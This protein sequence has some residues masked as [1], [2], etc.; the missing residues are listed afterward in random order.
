MVHR[1]TVFFV[2]T[3]AVSSGGVFFR[4]RPSLP[5]RSPHDTLLP[6]IHPIPV[7]FRFLQNTPFVSLSATPLPWEVGLTGEFIIPA[8]PS[9]ERR[10][11]PQTAAATASLGP[12]RR[13]S[14]AGADRSGGGA[15]NSSATPSRVPLQMRLEHVTALSLARN[16]LTDLDLSLGARA[17]ARPA[18]ASAPPPRWV[19]PRRRIIHTSPSALR[20][21][22]A[23]LV[24]LKSLDIS[25][26]LLRRLHGAGGDASAS[27]G[28]DDGGMGGAI[29]SLGGRESRDVSLP[30]SLVMLEVMPV[31]SAM[32]GSGRE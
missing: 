5:P 21:V 6:P 13:P 26:N 7:P 20:G 19:A 22:L 4:H 29:G 31:H 2:R 8:T 1:F 23:M 16:K 10:S 17:R 11:P 18:R 25:H 9:P 28:G 24:S 3:V 12:R 15:R 32:R 27:G 14:P 30:R